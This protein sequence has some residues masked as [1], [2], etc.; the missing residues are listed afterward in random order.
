MSPSN[1]VERKEPWRLAGELLELARLDTA[2]ADLYLQR[3]RDLL[4]AEMTEAQLAALKD[5]DAEAPLLQ[6]R[7]AN[8]MEIG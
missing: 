7:V 1:P 5:M 6:N 4:G 2:Y 8:A 3:G